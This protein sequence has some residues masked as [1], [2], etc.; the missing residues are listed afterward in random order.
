M[1]E[2]KKLHENILQLVQVI[3]EGDNTKLTVNYNQ[4]LIFFK[5]MTNK[6]IRFYEQDY[7][8]RHKS[9]GTK[10]SYKHYYGSVKSNF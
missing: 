5:M 4:Q 1:R 7:A 2:K 10:N 9:N 6:N 3:D 8:E